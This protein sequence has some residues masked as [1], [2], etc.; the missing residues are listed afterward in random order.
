MNGEAGKWAA[1]VAIRL[2]RSLRE[3]RCQLERNPDYKAKGGDPLVVGLLLVLC[4]AVMHEDNWESRRELF[5]VFAWCQWPKVVNVRERI[6]EILDGV[7]LRA[8]YWNFN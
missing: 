8:D 3:I 4:D 7:N 6:E 5:K 2:G 1:W